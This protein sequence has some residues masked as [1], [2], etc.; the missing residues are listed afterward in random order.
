MGDKLE[1]T[2]LTKDNY[3]TWKFKAKHLLTA[4]GL[5][6]YVDGSETAPGSSASADEKKQYQSRRAKAHSHIVLSVSDELLYL[7]TECEDAKDTWEKLQSHFERDSLAN[8]L[9]LK[10]KYFRTVMSENA[11]IE[12]HLRDMKEIT[13]KLAAIKAPVSEEDQVVTL[14]GSLPES[15]DRLVTALEAHGDRLT[16]AYVTNAFLNA[17]QKRSEEQRLPATAGVSSSNSHMSDLMLLY[18]LKPKLLIAHMSRRAISVI[19]LII[20]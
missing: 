13:N 11:S 3:P 1:I 9:F 12:S 18:Q 16:L 14:L 10:K 15:Y 19:A 4:K 6:G 5:F 8:R 7:I 17:E 2:K 20:T